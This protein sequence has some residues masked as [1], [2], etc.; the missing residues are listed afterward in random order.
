MRRKKIE[1]LWVFTKQEAT[2]YLS[3]GFSDMPAR[4]VT[5]AATNDGKWFDAVMSIDD[6][7]WRVGDEVEMVETYNFR[8]NDSYWMETVW[9]IQN[10]NM[11]PPTTGG[12]CRGSE[13]VCGANNVYGP[14]NGAHSHWCDAAKGV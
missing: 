12:Q 3:E 11:P 13:C 1:K 2:N 5:I 9:L 4:Y 14:N 7:G 10:D 8:C 6:V